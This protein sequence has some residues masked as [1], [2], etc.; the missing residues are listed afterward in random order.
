[1]TD[2]LA[3]S[4]A[5]VTSD[6]DRVTR[7][8]Q[9]P[10]VPQVGEWYRVQV[11]AKEDGEG[12]GTRVRLACVTDV[13]SNYVEV[14]APSDQRVSVWRIHADRF[15]TVAEPAP[16]AP[17]EIA[18][19]ID[20][21]R[22]QVY[23]LMEQ[24]R[25]LA[26]DLGISPRALASGPVESETQALVTQANRAPVKEYKAALVKAQ[27]ETLPEIFKRIHE[28]SSAMA[29]WMNAELIPLQAEAKQL[30]PAIDA[31][32]G[33]IFN[34]ELYA[35]LT[36]E[37]VQV[38]DGKPAPMHERVHLFQRRHYMDEECLAEYKTGGMTFNKLTDF[39]AW[40]AAP[41]N[42]ERLLPKPRSVVAFRIRRHEKEREFP[43][44]AAYLHFVFSREKDADMLTYLYLR[45][46][47]QLF[48]LSTGIEFGEKLFPDLEARQLD[49]TLYAVIEG[50]RVRK[51]LTGGEY[52]GLCREAAERDAEIKAEQAKLKK[53]DRWR[54]STHN[55]AKDTIDDAH[56]W[57]QDSVYFDDIAAFVNTQI[58]LYN[59]IALVLQ[60]LLDRSPVFHPHPAWQLWTPDG[61]EQA[62]ALVL[63]QDRA[64]TVGEKPDFE[65]YRAALN[66]SLQVGSVTVGQDD[67]WAGLEADKYNAR[68]SNRD[69][70][71]PV[72]RH[73]P[74]GNPGPG[75]L[76][77]V[78]KCGRKACAFTW[79]RQP[80]WS[81]IARRRNDYR[82]N[83][84]DDEP[85]ACRLEVPKD[86]LLNVSAYT[87]GDF[88]RFFAD[89]RTRAD[90]LQWA[91]Y[92][93]EAEEY[94][95]GNR[96]L[97]LPDLEEDDD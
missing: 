87:P 15:Y 97:V 25:Q 6:T 47:E 2:A 5:L 17:A 1:M 38:R 55:S 71:P 59:R 81:T 49:G 26:L 54:V 93:L 88:K 44:L 8:E 12:K 82:W 79:H 48:R 67:Y 78:T 4:A 65:A 21:H 72:K 31:I 70:N 89:P 95:A 80:E 84:E 36:E 30:E 11:K 20:A 34:V 73:R 94:H 46:G 27:K 24:A 39:D 10:H 22:T 83:R 91:P 28:H 52:E 18:R 64:L 32:K 63:D 51:L 76:A 68:R 41:A 77:R 69:W 7:E 96:K 29:T 74:Y 62:V 61:F 40:M 42:F 75:V 37:V 13:G 23:G 33:R 45:N 16:D 86:R 56:R 50:E 43:S 92:L 57:D 85:I 9:A 58:E 66:A 14:T 60:G 19:K 53:A 90:Y 35:G 3:K